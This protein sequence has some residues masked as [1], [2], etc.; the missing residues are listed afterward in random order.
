MKTSTLS[1]VAPSQRFVILDALR[2]F[3]LLGICLA[4][5]PEFSLYTF[6]PAEAADAMP[7]A[8]AD[9]WARCLLYALVDGKF[10]TLFSLLFGIG[11]SII[12]GNAL[13]KGADGMRIFYR[14]MAVLTVIGLLH[15]M[16]LWSGDILMLYALLGMLL[17][18]FRNAS[19]RSLL[20][21]A[22]VLLLLPACVD[23][24]QALCGFDLSAPAVERQ[25]EWCARF[26]ITEDNFAYWLRDARDYTGVLQ[27]LVQGAWERMYEFIEGNRYFKVLGLFL[28]G[29][30]IGRNRLYVKLD[31]L[32]PRLRLVTL[33]GL[34]WSLP[35]S[36]LYS[37]S[38]VG[39][40]PWGKM[41]HT[42]LY[43]LSVYPLALAYLTALCLLFLLTKEARLW[44]WIAAP[45]RMALSNYIGQTLVG[46]LL[47]YGVGLGW[48]AS[49]GLLHTELI[50]LAVYALQVLCS[51]LWLARFAFGPLEWLWRMLTYGK[52][53]SLRQRR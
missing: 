50:A 2:G 34:L 28:V 47:F 9:R 27:F 26:G 18:L 49:A 8:T 51:R 14:R 40:H 17:P 38:A 24:V 46:I 48:G 11:F 22:A 53:L 33:V 21:W 31:D 41:A 6:L 45:G 52:P 32:R 36:A 35:L 23:A 37:W 7:L 29:F 16:L 1:P 15:L 42:L 3:A 13:R 44:R 12:M 10:Y 25:W 39:G 20:T 19:N 4:N 5:Y 43:T 30:W